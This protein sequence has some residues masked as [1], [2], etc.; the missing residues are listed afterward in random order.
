MIITQKMLENIDTLDKIYYDLG[1]GLGKSLIYGIIDHKFKHAYGI[2]LSKERQNLAQNTL[3]HFDRE[4]QNKI[5]YLNGD[6]LDEQYNYKDADIVFISNL[7]F[8]REINHKIA[9]K[10]NNELKPNVIILSSSTLSAPRLKLRTKMEMK[11]TWSND[12]SLSV[13]DVI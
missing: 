6:I 1:S 4:E 8:A 13:Y 12:S 5:T 3:N 11:M 10:L 7:L 2:E 9:T